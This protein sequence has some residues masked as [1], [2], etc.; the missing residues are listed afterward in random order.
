MRFDLK[1][2]TKSQTASRYGIDNT[3]SEK[4]I[5]SLKILHKWVVK[6]LYDAYGNKL[7]IN[8]GFRCLKLNRKIGS[9]DKSQHTKGEA[10]DLEV[11]GVDNKKLWGI[12]KRTLE[13]DQLIL[14][15]YKAGKSQSGWV[16]I[17]FKNLKENRK[18]AFSIG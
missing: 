9:K 15:F 11:K 10:V 1:I 14:E 2:Y 7:I 8:S 17:S 16:H 13:Y 18:Q 12:I 5:K 4:E 6:P 3:P